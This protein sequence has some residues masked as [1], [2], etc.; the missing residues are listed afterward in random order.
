V[1]KREVIEALKKAGMRREA[2]IVERGSTSQVEL[3]WLFN[4]ASKIINAEAKE[5]E[6]KARALSAKY[7]KDGK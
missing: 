6:M 3:E 7:F 1:K 5:A 4:Q 2:G